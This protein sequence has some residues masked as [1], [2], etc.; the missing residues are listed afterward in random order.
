MGVPDPQG[1]VQCSYCGTK[2][3]LPPTDATKERRNL[4]RYRELCR[5]EKQAKNWKNVLKYADEILEIDPRDVDAWIDKA[6][7]AGSLSF[8]LLPRLDEAL[9]YLNN[10]SELSPD[11]PR[12]SETRNLV[13][14]VLFNSYVQQALSLSRQAQERAN[15]G[16]WLRDHAAKYANESMGYLLLAHRIKPDDSTNLQNVKTVSDQGRSLGLQWNQEVQDILLKIEQAKA[17]QAAENRLAMLRD[18]LSRR[19]AELE[20][21]NHKK[22]G[23]FVNMEIEDV[24]NE[25]KKISL[26]IGKLEKATPG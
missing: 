15:M 26:E 13:R 11:D 10:A 25:I 24:Q 2:I 12:L 23:F 18:K 8:Y 1:V 4:E 19:Q 17:Q 6:L 21:L 7:A 22:K 16:P 20:K 3:L 14:D 9:G 5:S